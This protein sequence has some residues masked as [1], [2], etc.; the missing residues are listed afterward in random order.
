MWRLYGTDQFEVDFET[1]KH[2]PI[3]WSD[4]GSAAES[5][6]QEVLVSQLNP[7]AKACT[8]T[9][10]TCPPRMPAQFMC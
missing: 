2:L 1:K 7:I 6:P 3:S 9:R 8:G 4:G 10:S 5:S